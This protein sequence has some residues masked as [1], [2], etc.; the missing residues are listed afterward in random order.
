M[1][2]NKIIDTTRKFISNKLSNAAMD[3]P[4]IGFV[5]PIILRVINNNTYK[6]RSAPSLVTDEYGE[7]D[8]YS[9]LG[10][11]TKSLMDTNPFIYNIPPLGDVEIGGGYIKINVPFTNKRLA[12]SK[13]DLD[14]FKEL[15]KEE[16]V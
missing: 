6:L 2:V 13:D 4:M 11:M 3:N 8:M 16:T 14:Q 9:L 7:I 1:K 5:K 10:D 12:L 15:F